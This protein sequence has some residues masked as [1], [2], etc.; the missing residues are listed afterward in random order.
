VFHASL[1]S[2]YHKTTAH[3]PNFSRPPPELIDGEEEYQVEQIL[4]H[5]YH[6]HA[7]AL[8]YLIKWPDYLE[9]D[10]TWEPTHHIHAQDLIKAY[11]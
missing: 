8:Q 6:G 5:Q 2:P 7:K 4:G 10:N 3:G 9:S 11:H 1:L